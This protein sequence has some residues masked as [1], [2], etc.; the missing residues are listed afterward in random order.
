MIDIFVTFHILP[1]ETAEFERL[2]Q[3]LL[4]PWLICNAAPSR[5][6]RCC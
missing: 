2:H 6:S 1:G 3:Q 4:A 5:R